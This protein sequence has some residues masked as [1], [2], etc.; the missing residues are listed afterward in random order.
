[1]KSALRL[2]TWLLSGALAAS[3]LACTPARDAT[4]VEGDLKVDLDADPLAL[5]PAR[6]VVIAR[7]DARAMA[8]NQTTGASLVAL[9][10]AYSPGGTFF[11]IDPSKDVDEITAGGYSFAGVD[12]GAV[13]RGRFDPA[14]IE[15]KA[16][17]SVGQSATGPGAL[18]TTLLVKTTYAGHS[19]Y[20]VANV[21]L[22]VLSSKTVIFGTE[23]ALR[24]IL[25]KLRD[26]AV[27]RDVDPLLAETV[28]AG[29]AQKSAV[30]AA[31]SFGAQPFPFDLPFGG[32]LKSLTSA[33]L[34]ADL[35]DPGL[36][37]HGALTYPDEEGAK[38]A[39]GALKQLATLASFS[40]FV[41]TLRNLDVKTEG[42]SAKLAFAV[43][44]RQLRGLLGTLVGRAPH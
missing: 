28:A 3:T 27:T 34:F 4:D 40:S 6:P 41:P 42:T 14:A 23:G 17:A 5:L 21:G 24:R 1:M 32:W 20:T 36:D 11:G 16:D 33:R 25:D 35:E 30:A 8:D 18:A 10:A 44:D 2:T 13:L 37:V 9:A 26:H 12:V 19:L 43:D 7:I 29:I 15:A 38:K 39:A 22:C 31:V